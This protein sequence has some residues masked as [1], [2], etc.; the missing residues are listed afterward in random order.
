[1][2]I[3]I[4]KLVDTFMGNP[5]PLE[6]KVER[7]N[8]G[9]P[10]NAIPKDLEEAI[11]LQE[12]ADLHTGA[13]NQQAMQAGGAQPSVVQKLQQ[14][15]ASAQQRQQAAP[16]AAPQ[17]MPQGAPRPM[18][19]QPVMAARGGSLNQLM[20]NLAHH[21]DGGGIVAFDGTEG[22]DVKDESLID[23]YAAAPKLAAE[24]GVPVWAYRQAQEFLART[25]TNATVGEVAMALAKQGGKG[26]AALGKGAVDVA[27]LAGTGPGM[28][29]L[30]GGV[31][32][33]QFTA[34]VMKNNPKLREAYTDNYMLGAMDP[35]NALGAAILNES[36]G[37]QAA[38]QKRQEAV[39]ADPETEKLKRLA[40][41]KAQTG[42]NTNP[43]LQPRPSRENAPRPNGPAGPNKPGI[44]TVKPDTMDPMEAAIRANIMKELAKDE[45]AEWQKGAKRHEDFMGINQ[46]LAPKES[47]IAERE[48]MLKKAQNERLPSWVEGLSRASKPV[49]SGGIGTLLNSLGSGMEDQRKAYNAEDLKFFDD[50]SAMKDEVAKLKLEGKYKAAAAGEASIKDAIANKRQAEQSGTSLLTN[51]EN[52]EMRKQ[53]AKEGMLNRAAQAAAGQDAKNMSNAI[54]AVKNDEVINRLQKR[55]EE[56]GKMPTPSNRAAADDILRQIDARQTAIYKKFKVLDGL[57]TMAEAPGVNSPG[58]T[59]KPGW[60]IKPI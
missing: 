60:G 35:D 2:S 41:V 11:A 12:I 8:K 27:K 50:I 48:A 40:A 1:M 34:D 7:D 16:P 32:A 6:A 4:D 59:S 18:P 53:I 54:N 25:G 49:V 51:K 5:Q 37:K 26:V 47:R 14:I 44:D 23:R 33:T 30:A 20:S 21:Y 57:S 39:D 28:A 19:Q 38:V 17:G 52:A 56:L 15:L 3:G 36:A 42:Q 10:P 13:Q 45:D 29:V 31:P 9:K 58:G 22:S 46:L 55:A 43:A 24:L